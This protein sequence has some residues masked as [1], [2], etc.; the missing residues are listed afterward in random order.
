LSEH[1]K[2]A[3]LLGKVAAYT[4]IMVK[5]PGSTIFVSLAETY[6]KL[7]MYDD[8][9]Q[10][11][12]K[13]LRRH[14]DLSS[15]HIVM[16]R[17]LC[18]LEAYEGSSASFSRALELDSDSLAALVGYA[19]VCILLGEE[20]QARE[21]LLRARKLSPADPV[22]NKLLLSLPQAPAPIEAEP[23]VEEPVE[24]ATPGTSGKG[25]ASLT[26]A[27]LY[28]KQ[29]LTAKALAMYQQLSVDAPADLTLRRKIRD[30]EF[31]GVAPEEPVV[32]APQLDEPVATAV[33]PESVIDSAAT[34]EDS[35][36]TLDSATFVAKEASELGATQ[37]VNE[38]NRLLDNIHRRRENV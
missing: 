26:L 29:G 17:I 4:E 6:R 16:A 37:V 18:Q 30:L 24:S 13:G 25:L 2:H 8:G 34:M 33:V 28:E 15:A 36:V 31:G 9:R 21:L 38:L 3:T 11:L 5:D 20:E 10:I 23:S 1:D 14:P 19:R 27:N 22:I 12:T 7:G 32:S 35:D